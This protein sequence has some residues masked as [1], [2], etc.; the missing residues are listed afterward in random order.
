MKQTLVNH[1]EFIAFITD[2]CY[3]KCMNNKIY[4]A[5]SILS[6]DFSNIRSSIAMIEKADADW[7]HLDVMDGSFVPNL[8]FG[9]KFVKDLR[10]FSKNVFDVHL[11]VNHPETMINAFA[12]A[13]SDYITFHLEAAVHVHRIIQQIKNLGCKAGI[14][15][16][17]STPVSAVREVLQYVDLVLVMTV[18]PGFGGQKL[19]SGSLGKIAELKRIREKNF[20]DY[21]IS[22]DGGINRQTAPSVVEAGADILVSGSAFFNAED[23]AGE[24][25]LLKGNIPV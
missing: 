12:D 23:P 13:G 3:Y 9:P 15:I 2:I 8:T 1:T 11:M 25:K 6:A 18:N 19:I 22:V 10:P 24:V 5:P 21:F 16:V 14:S 4:I 20:Y 17:P 7:V